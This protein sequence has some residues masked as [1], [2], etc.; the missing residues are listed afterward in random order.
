MNMIQNLFLYC[1]YLISIY[2]FY[3]IPLLIK[4]AIT[5]SQDQIVIQVKIFS[6]TP[7]SNILPLF[8]G[9]LQSR[10]FY[11][12]IHLATLSFINVKQYNVL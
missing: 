11:M 12:P 6:Y 1:K 9:K 8:L 7:K 10:C 2:Y 4:L 5:T 3:L